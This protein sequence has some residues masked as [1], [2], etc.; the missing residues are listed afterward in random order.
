MAE[1]SPRTGVVRFTVEFDSAA[2]DSL[3]G[4]MRD[5]WVN[6]VADLLNGEGY[7]SSISHA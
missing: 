3:P 5:E 6:Q 7:V 1:Q 2:W 4:D